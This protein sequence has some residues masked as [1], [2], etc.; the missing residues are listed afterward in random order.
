[1]DDIGQTTRVVYTDE[2]GQTQTPGAPRDCIF[3]G[4]D[5][6]RE[7]TE[8]IDSL[9]ATEPEVW[10]DAGLRL[11]TVLADDLPISYCTQRR[12]QDLGGVETV[13]QRAMLEW[14]PSAVVL[15][16]K[17]EPVPG[18]MCIVGRVAAHRSGPAHRVARPVANW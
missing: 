13:H 4:P 18:G 9:I 8:A 3:T 11:Q 17:S 12:A 1:V 15:V 10:E 7:A 5:Q 16:G 14:G 2:M 6:V